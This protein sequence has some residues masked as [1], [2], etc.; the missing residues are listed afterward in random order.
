MWLD[1][2][3]DRMQSLKT[4]VGAMAAAPIIIG[5]VFGVGGILPDATIVHGTE[6]A[7]TV[8]LSLLGG[9]VSYFGVPRLLKPLEPGDR[10]GDSELGESLNRIQAVTPV[11]AA[12]AESG[13]MLAIVMAFVGQY[14]GGALL[15]AAPV[16]ALSVYFAAFPSPGRLETYKRRLES[17]GRRSG[18]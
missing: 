2:R 17:A 13:F 15:V 18:L 11:A 4:M 7:V 12:L 1:S 6:V 8:G 3:M 10:V 9:L 16:G 14:S 5:L